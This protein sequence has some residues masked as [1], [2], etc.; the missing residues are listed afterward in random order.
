MSLKAE[1]GEMWQVF[2]LPQLSLLVFSHQLCFP[3]F[4]VKPLSKPGTISHLTFYELYNQSKAAINSIQR[5]R[6]KNDWNT[7]RCRQ[8]QLRNLLWH[9]HVL[10]SKSVWF[11]TGTTS[12]KNK[13]YEG[14]L[15]PKEFASNTDTKLDFHFSYVSHP[16]TFNMYVMSMLLL[17]KFSVACE[18]AT[19]RSLFHLHFCQLKSFLNAITNDLACSASP[20]FSCLIYCRLRLFDAAVFHLPSPVVQTS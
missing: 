11:D 18:P 19:T 10:H 15:R 16:T 3:T 20:W 5:K 17:G 2:V 4:F 14:N 8:T 9:K 6:E 7:L 12:V 13:S 1:V